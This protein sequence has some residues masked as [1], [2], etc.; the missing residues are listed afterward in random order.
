MEP[1]T[2]VCRNPGP[3]LADQRIVAI[4]E[5]NGGDKCRAARLLGEK[6]RI[7]DSSRQRLLAD[8]VLAAGQRGGRE[9]AVR[10]IGSA[11]MDDV[12][13]GGIDELQRVTGCALGPENLGADRGSFR[14]RAGD[15]DDVGAR[16]AD[17]ARM[18]PAH[19]A[20]A[21]DPRTE[22]IC[23]IRLYVSSQSAVICR[24][25]ANLSFCTT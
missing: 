1:T 8:D 24:L 21:D 3:C 25:R 20:G 16:R 13:V 12:D 6:L 22:S 17:R 18:H 2:L 9:I 11:D 23:H 14:R 10:T 15:G 4:D 5:G 7:C 19:K